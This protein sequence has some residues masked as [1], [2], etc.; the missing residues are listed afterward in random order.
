MDD[1]PERPNRTRP[2]ARVYL[3]PLLK[4]KLTPR[5]NH[6]R[7]VSSSVWRSC[8]CRTLLPLKQVA[9]IVSSTPQGLRAR[10]QAWGEKKNIHSWPPPQISRFRKSGR[11]RSFDNIIGPWRFW[12]T[13][14]AR[15]F[16]VQF[17]S[18]CKFAPNEIPPETDRENFFSR[19]RRTKLSFINRDLFPESFPLDNWRREIRDLVTLCKI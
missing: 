7:A 2:I 18:R 4:I 9:K 15:H 8:F 12:R 11:Y 3:S 6:W 16:R 5:W 14:Q 10:W 1:G 17:F 13:R 19:M